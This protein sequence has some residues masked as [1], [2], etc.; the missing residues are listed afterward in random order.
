LKE[1]ITATGYNH[2]NL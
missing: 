2:L 1:F